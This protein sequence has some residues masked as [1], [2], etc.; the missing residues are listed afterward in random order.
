MPKK[1]AVDSGYMVIWEELVRRVRQISDPKEEMSEWLR[2]QR[3]GQIRGLAQALSLMAF[4]DGSNEAIMKI[5]N[6]TNKAVQDMD[7]VEW[8]SKMTEQFKRT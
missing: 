4:G 7:R 6:V 3:T 2:A 8:A 1:V 5:L